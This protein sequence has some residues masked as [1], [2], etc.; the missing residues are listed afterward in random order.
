MAKTTVERIET[1][2]PEEKQDG[3]DVTTIESLT[4]EQLE[5]LASDGKVEVAAADDTPAEETT[6][7][8]IES[9]EQAAP[10]EPVEGGESQTPATDTSKDA[11]PKMYAGKFK[12]KEALK[13]AVLEIIKPLGY[14]AKTIQTLVSLAEKSGEWDAVEETYKDLESD[15]GKQAQAKHEERK[16]AEEIQPNPMEEQALEQFA[17]QHSVS[18]LKEGQVAKAM[19]RAGIAFPTTQEEF[20]DLSIQN[21]ALSVMLDDEFKRIK[22]G[23]M[24]L[25]KKEFVAR[26]SIPQQNKKSVEGAMESIRKQAEQV[27]LPID[28]AALN[29]W[30]EEAV[31]DDDVSTTRNGASLIKQKALVNKW[32]AENLTNIVKAASMKASAEKGRQVVADLKSMHENTT[33]TISTNGAL[34]KKPS[35]T[36]AKKVVATEADVEKLTPEELEE[37]YQAGVMARFD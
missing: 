31:K 20:E 15:L 27:G 11:E 33:K 34:P 6:V 36:S 9:E 35:T 22:S 1:T 30:M 3:L 2:T 7:E 25:A 13:K 32:S 28:D 19:L 10:A 12:D 24:E 21:P 5:K 16:Q 18:Q 4:E 14:N 23:V 29:A 26:T 17:N 37:L 8:K